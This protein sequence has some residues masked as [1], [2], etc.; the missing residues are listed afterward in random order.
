[1][2]DATSKNKLRYTLSKRER[3]CQRRTFDYLFAHGSA[4]KSGVLK[5]FFVFNPPASPDQASLSMA[6]AVPKRMFKR[7]V[8]RNLMKRRIREAFRLHKHQLLP[9][10][11]DRNSQLAILIKYQSKTLHS[12]ARITSDLARAFHYL[13]QHCEAQPMNNE[14]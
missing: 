2:K 5:F 8:D 6:I 14:G 9:C 1:M 11:T 12:S 4:Y 10:L 7:A 3:I 13:H